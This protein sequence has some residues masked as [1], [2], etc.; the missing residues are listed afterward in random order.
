MS[1]KKKNSLSNITGLQSGGLP[2]SQTTST[3]KAGRPVDPNSKRERLK[4]GELFKL[5]VTIPND[6]H[7]KLVVKAATEPD[8]DMSDIVTDLLNQHLQ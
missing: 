3:G 2:I 7:Q 5:T 6:L 8:K 1:D 4:R